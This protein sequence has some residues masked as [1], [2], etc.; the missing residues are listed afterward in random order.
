MLFLAAFGWLDGE[1]EY[2]TYK[3]VEADNREQAEQKAEKYICQLWGKDTITE[4]EWYM[5]SCG[6][7]AVKVESVREIRSMEELL[8]QIGKIE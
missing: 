1:S 6:Y 8:Q 4:G 5:P 3:G 2:I 7:P